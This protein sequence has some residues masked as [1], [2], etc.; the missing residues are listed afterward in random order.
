MAKVKF[1]TKMEWGNN[2]D[3]ITVS[4]SFY[5]TPAYSD[6]DYPSASSDAEIED[7]NACDQYGNKIELDEALLAQAKEVCWDHVECL[8]RQS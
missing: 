3:E 7:I 2:A 6:P 4:F 5:Y 8:E 1:N